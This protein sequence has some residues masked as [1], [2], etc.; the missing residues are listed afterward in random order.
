MLFF[1]YSL[2]GVDL[3]QIV[4]IPTHLLGALF[5]SVG[6]RVYIPEAPSIVGESKRQL[7]LVVQEQKEAG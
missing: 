3:A 1:T 6:H 5:I 4:I 7:V 2:E